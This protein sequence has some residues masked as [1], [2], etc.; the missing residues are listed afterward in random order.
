MQQKIAKSTIEFFRILP[1][2]IFISPRMILDQ[3]KKKQCG[4]CI[5]N[6]LNHVHITQ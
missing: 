5:E 2:K 4:T 3:I 1:T 6:V